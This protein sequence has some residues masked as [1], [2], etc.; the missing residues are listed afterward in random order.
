MTAAMARRM[1]STDSLVSSS[2]LAL[3]SINLNEFDFPAV[4]MIREPFAAFPRYAS[5]SC[6]LK[7]WT[8][9]Q[10][11]ILSLFRSTSVSSLDVTLI[12][13]HIR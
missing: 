3:S 5:L 1:L 11:A 7:D 8:S 4:A 2:I 9:I 13:E 6:S 10:Q 12:H